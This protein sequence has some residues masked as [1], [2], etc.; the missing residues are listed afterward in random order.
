MA[1][2]TGGKKSGSAAPLFEYL[3]TNASSIER[4]RTFAS[5]KM[6]RGRRG[7]FARISSPVT[8]EPPAIAR[9]RSEGV[10]KYSSFNRK[11]SELPN[12]TT[13]GTGSRV[14]RFSVIVVP[15]RVVFDGICNPLPN[16][17]VA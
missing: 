4:D 5:T 3:S 2:L 15:P 8:G 1:A 16:Q 13:E 10:A 14:Y 9:F 12:R 6:I 11:A 7:L 17:A